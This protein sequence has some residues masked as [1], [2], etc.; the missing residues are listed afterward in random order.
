MPT[1]VAARCTSAAQPYFEPFHWDGQIFLD[2]GYKLTC[3]AQAALNEAESIWP[4]KHCDALVS[5]GTGTSTEDS[6]SKASP[7][8]V[9]LS[10]QR[11][12][13]KAISARHIWKEFSAEFSGKL[14]LFRLDP[15]YKGGGF[16]LD[17]FKRLQ[18]IERQTNEWI[19]GSEQQDSLIRICDQLIAALFFFQ[20]VRVRQDGLLQGEI[21]CRLP[22]DIEG[23]QTLV[24]KMW[25][26]T[27]SN[28]FA[29]VFESKRTLLDVKKSLQPDMRGSELC[30][31]ADIQLLASNLPNLREITIRIEMRPLSVGLTSSEWSPISGSPYVLS[32]F[33][34]VFE[35]IST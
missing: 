29:V 5:L 21:R 18:E 26:Q 30:I 9:K 27:D 15:A 28:L 6:T 13:E 32:V 16:A 3:P 4:G 20:T 17:D 33:D 35:D 1:W 25:S 22:V 19:E 34:Q 24:D 7:H 12:I 11:I 10:Q 8:N 23:H 14:P 31:P 2:G